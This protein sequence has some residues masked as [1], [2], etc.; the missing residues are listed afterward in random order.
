MVSR[1]LPIRSAV[2]VIARG[3]GIA[4][5]PR[6]LTSE[7]GGGLADVTG[8]HKLL[9]GDRKPAMGNVEGTGEAGGSMSSARRTAQEI[10]PGS[11]VPCALC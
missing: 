5:K 9:R 3:F 1:W 6:G 4:L 8:T 2:E 7:Q 10:A 11:C